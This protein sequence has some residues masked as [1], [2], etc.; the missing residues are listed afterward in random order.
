M[1][2]TNAGGSTGPAGSSTPFTPSGSSGTV[3]GAPTG[4][5]ATPL[6]ASELRV[7]WTPPTSTGGSDI[8][9]Y[10]VQYQVDSGPWSDFSDAALTLG[11]SLR[12]TGATPG[13]YYSFRVAA[14]NATGQG[15]WS[16]PSTPVATG[17]VERRPGRV[18]GVTVDYAG[19]RNVTAT[20]RWRLPLDQG[21]EAVDRYRVRLK[22]NGGSY[23]TWFGVS[24]RVVVAENL[25]AG[26]GY[27]VQIQAH[28]AVGWG[29]S[30]S[31]TLSP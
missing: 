1:T 6:S 18:R 17:G 14:V 31:V 13:S 24:K 10:V 11:T 26:R 3:P 22:A 29:P 4:V 15:A 19:S 28:S 27:T 9:G 30:K 2:A 7:E 20:I 5:Y 23:G 8:G 12:V 21:T 16:Q 25:R